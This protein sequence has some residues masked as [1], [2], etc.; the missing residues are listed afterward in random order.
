ML[1]F[2][3][4]LSRH[5]F[6]P[7]VS[8]LIIFLILLLKGVGFIFAL[9]I[10]VAL[11]ISHFVLGK[12]LAMKRYDRLTQQI[13][14]TIRAIANAMK[15][16]YSF[17]QAF[18]F[19]AS[20]SVDPIG[21][22]L[23]NAVKEIEYNFSTDAVLTRLRNNAN[24]RDIDLVVDGILMQHKIGGNLVEMLENIAYITSERMKLENELKVLTAQGRVSGVIVAMLFP[25]SLFM[26]TMISRE[27]VDVLYNTTIGQFFL[28][29]AI[30]LEIIGFKMIWNITHVKL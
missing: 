8:G 1:L 6:A 18:I 20:E 9:C 29:L 11:P 5:K 27:Y 26:F 23:R 15:A 10:G 4:K 22:Y 7:T 2:L 14:E 13:P 28:V 25:I 17:E 3:R 16:G 21:T 12:Y 24:H 19:V 30:E